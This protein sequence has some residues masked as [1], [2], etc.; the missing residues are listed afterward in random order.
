M[1]T[2]SVLKNTKLTSYWFPYLVRRNTFSQEIRVTNWYHPIPSHQNIPEAA[3]PRRENTKH[4][5]EMLFGKSNSE[6]D[7]FCD[8][9]ARST[10]TSANKYHVSI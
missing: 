9:Q 6:M 3:F 7:R 1:S 4:C 8:G 2:K 10:R 5:K